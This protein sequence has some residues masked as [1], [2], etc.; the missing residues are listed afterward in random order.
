MVKHVHFSFQAK[1]LYYRYYILSIR[2]IA[3]LI[4]S[5]VKAYADNSREKMLL[6]N[7]IDRCVISQEFTSTSFD[8]QTANFI[9]FSQR[10]QLYCLILLY[11]L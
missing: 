10:N 4:S 11:T 3:C 5:S 6:L 1:L 8:E 2:A 7:V 9:N